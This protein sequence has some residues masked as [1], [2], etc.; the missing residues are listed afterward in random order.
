[1]NFGYISKQAGSEQPRTW[2]DTPPPSFAPK[3]Q[4][5]LSP[6]KRRRRVPA[7]TLTKQKEHGDPVGAASVVQPHTDE[8]VDQKPAREAILGLYGQSCADGDDQTSESEPENETNNDASSAES[9]LILKTPFSDLKPGTF[10]RSLADE[11]GNGDFGLGSDGESEF[12]AAT[13]ENISPVSSS[14]LGR[15]IS[16]DVARD[17][18]SEIGN[19]VA[20]STKAESI[21]SLEETIQEI[22][23][24]GDFL[25]K[26]LASRDERIATLEAD[27]A[28]LTNKTVKAMSSTD[29]ST[30]TETLAGQ[31]CQPTYPREDDN[32]Q[33][34][35]AIKKVSSPPPASSLTTQGSSVIRFTRTQLDRAKSLYLATANLVDM[36]SLPGYVLLLSRVKRSATFKET[37]DIF[38]NWVQAAVFFLATPFCMIMS[39][40]LYLSMEQEKNMWMQANALTRK[41]LLGCASGVSGGLFG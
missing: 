33:Q 22:L 14:H 36:E 38:L 17:A 41:H 23:R 35:I 30:T 24:E 18:A 39:F 26:E 10:Q 16:S 21:Q 12:S 29:A 8:R 7:G 31:V 25:K 20:S 13:N 28:A 1:M 27:K 40:S 34:V 3:P 37:V 5:M 19:S 9:S 2:D 32:E 11:L 6:P 4:P 15:P